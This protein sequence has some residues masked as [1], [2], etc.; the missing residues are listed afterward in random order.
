MKIRLSCWNTLT[1]VLMVAV[2]NTSSTPLYAYDEEM[3]GDDTAPYTIVP[4]LE[5]TPKNATDPYFGPPGYRKN[6]PKP[7]EAEAPPP[8]QRLLDKVL[9]KAPPPPPKESPQ[10]TP[11]MIIQVGSREFKPSPEPLLRLTRSLP[12]PNGNR[13]LPDVY[14]VQ[15]LGLLVD[16]IG[17]IHQQP[18][19][20]QLLNRGQMVMELPLTLYQNLGM[21]S[22][23]V[24]TTTPNALTSPEERRAPYRSIRLLESPRG[25]AG[26]L[27]YQIGDLQFITPP[28]PFSFAD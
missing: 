9:G 5:N 21:G 22:P 24:Q 19:A 10:I 26:Q 8:K 13:L 11:E 6:R 16:G 4:N 15:P 1:L 12:L 28:F 3:W 25:E 7:Q 14:L 20:I 27:L 2:L 18:Y 17:R 23:L